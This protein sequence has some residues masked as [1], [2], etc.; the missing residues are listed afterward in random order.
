MTTTH[1]PRWSPLLR[2]TM[3][4][5]TEANANGIEQQQHDPSSAMIPNISPNVKSVF[6]SDGAAGPGA[7]G[8]GGGGVT[9]GT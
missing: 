8:P 4:R 6:V 9:G 5:T 2:M 3:P 7:P 1:S